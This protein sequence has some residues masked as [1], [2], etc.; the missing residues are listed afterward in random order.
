MCHR[1]LKAKKVAPG[2]IKELLNGDEENK[3]L[4]VLDGYD[5]YTPGN[6]NLVNCE[7][8]VIQHVLLSSIFKLSSKL[9]NNENIFLHHKNPLCPKMRSLSALIREE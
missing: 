2:E 4:I 7:V 8:F 5:E 9:L 6:L 3:I 1:G